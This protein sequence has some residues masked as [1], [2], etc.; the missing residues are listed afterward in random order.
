MKKIL[1]SFLLFA[2]ALVSTA[3]L[4]SCGGD[5]EDDD[6]PQTSQA[7]LDFKIW[8]TEDLQKIADVKTTGI[9]QLSCT[10]KATLEYYDAYAEKQTSEGYESQTI[11]FEGQQADDAKFKVSV[12]LKPNWKE[13]IGDKQKLDCR[14]A[15]RYIYTK[16]KEQRANYREA[17]GGNSTFNVSKI[18]ADKENEEIFEELINKMSYS[19]PP[20]KL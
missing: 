7:S 18:T 2:V 10:K 20:A 9:S 8:M 5:D 1:Y 17:P 6:V 14:F 4:V 3:A 15:G 19:Y 11:H 12:Q 13:L 16:G